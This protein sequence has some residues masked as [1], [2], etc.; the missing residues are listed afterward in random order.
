MW[1]EL[2]VLVGRARCIYDR[3]PMCICG[4]GTMYKWEELDVLVP[5]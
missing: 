1:D 4:W 2:D 5:E 3:R